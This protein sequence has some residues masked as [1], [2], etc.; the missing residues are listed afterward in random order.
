MF[1]L[2]LTIISLSVAL[3]LYWSLSSADPQYVNHVHRLVRD[4]GCG[5]DYSVGDGG[6]RGVRGTETAQLLPSGGSG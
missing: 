4:G 6:P 2:L 1:A 3:L 5:G